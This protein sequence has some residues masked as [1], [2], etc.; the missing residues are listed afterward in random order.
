[1]TWTSADP[2]PQLA[3]D[4]PP[5]KAAGRATILATAIGEESFTDTNGNGY[6]DPGEPFVHLG[7]PYSDNNENGAHDSSEYFLDFNQNG[8]VGPPGP[9][10]DGVQRN[11]LHGQ[12]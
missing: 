3:S 8:V 12:P 10:R 1:M 7:E 9:V 11:H 4:S 6:W 5:L 2:R